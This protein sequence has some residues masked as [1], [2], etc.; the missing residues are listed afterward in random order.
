MTPPGTTRPRKRSWRTCPRRRS[1]SSKRPAFLKSH[2]R[3]AQPQPVASVNYSRSCT[4]LPPVPMT[5]CK[6]IEPRC[7]GSLRMR[8][9][10]AT[11]TATC[12]DA[13]ELL[14]YLEGSLDRQH[15]QAIDR[16]LD[17]CAACRSIKLTLEERALPVSLPSRRAELRQ[18]QPWAER[19]R[20]TVARWD[21]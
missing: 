6:F 12:P 2:L 7:S 8:M 16:H 15:S 13:A 11:D 14:E 19:R 1:P 4:S 17:T 10:K 18:P 3:A 5:G 20:P 9:M 21:L